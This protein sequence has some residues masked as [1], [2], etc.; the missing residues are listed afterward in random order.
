MPSLSFIGDETSYLRIQNTSDLN[1]GTDDFT[2]Y[3]LFN[4]ISSNII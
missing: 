2:N 3:N 1:F 4:F